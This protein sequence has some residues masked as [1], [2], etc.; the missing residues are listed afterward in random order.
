MF[1]QN[2]GIEH[3]YCPEIPIQTFRQN[4]RCY[5]DSFKYIFSKWTLKYCYKQEILNH[6]C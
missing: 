5:S 1:D 4:N 3:K 6:Y 2:L